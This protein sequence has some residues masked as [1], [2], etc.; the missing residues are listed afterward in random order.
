MS[1]LNYNLPMGSGSLE[2]VSQSFGIGSAPNPKKS[3]KSRSHE[4]IAG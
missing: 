3:S 1:I 4:L 2:G